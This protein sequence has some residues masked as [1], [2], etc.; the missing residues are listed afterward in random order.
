MP[1]SLARARD[2]DSRETVTKGAWSVVTGSHN[3][4]MIRCTIAGVSVIAIF[5]GAARA[6]E[7]RD[8]VGIASLPNFERHGIEKIAQLTAQDRSMILFTI[9]DETIGFAKD[10]AV[11][12]IGRDWIGRCNRWTH[13]ALS[14]D[15]RL[16]AYVSDGESE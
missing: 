9:A 8:P 3:T 6:Q 14:H 2:C 13:P 4:R 16:V 7:I 12:R 1:V 15:G 5:I 10:G 11:G